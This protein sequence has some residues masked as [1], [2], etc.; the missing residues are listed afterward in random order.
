MAVTK[1]WAARPMVMAVGKPAQGPGASG[2]GRFARRYWSRPDSAWCTVPKTRQFAG[3]EGLV[4]VNRVSAPGELLPLLESISNSQERQAAAERTFDF[5]ERARPLRN[6]GALAALRVEGRRLLPMATIKPLMVMRAARVHS[7][8]P[9]LVGD[10]LCG[11]LF[12]RR[13][14]AR[15]PFSRRPGLP[16]GAPSADRHGPDADA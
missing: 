5:L 11:L 16:S 7:G 10:L 2:P 1:S 9:A 14:M 13:R 3:A 12:G 8:F 15:G 4:N 6:V